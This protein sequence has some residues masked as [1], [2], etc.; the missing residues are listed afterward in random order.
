MARCEIKWIV[1]SQEVNYLNGFEQ[2]TNHSSC[3]WSRRCWLLC[4]CVRI[5][6]RNSNMPSRRRRIC[7]CRSSCV[8]WRNENFIETYMTYQEQK[9]IQNEGYIRFDFGDLFSPP[10]EQN[11]VLK[12]RLIY[13]LKRLLCV[14]RRALVQWTETGIVNIEISRFYG[15]SV[16]QNVGVWRFPPKKSEVTHAAMTIIAVSRQYWNDNKAIAIK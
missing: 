14:N 2:A 7:H 10:R 15:L 8:G 6:H 12:T 5:A 4:L 1:V 16:W 3:I 11:S 9:N 13:T